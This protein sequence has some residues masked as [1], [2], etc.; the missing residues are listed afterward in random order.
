MPPLQ[1]APPLRL[2]LLSLSLLLLLFLGP[3]LAGAQDPPVANTTFGKVV[4]FTRE[5][6]DIW[7]NVPYAA[8]PV[9]DLRFRPPRDPQPWTEALD[10]LAT[11]RMCPQNRNNKTRRFDGSEDCLILNVYAPANRSS[12][13]NGQQPLLPV[14][15]FIHGGGF[16]SGSGY[17]YGVNLPGL[18]DLY[19]GAQFA[20]QT[21]SVV[22]GV[23]YRLGL[24]G[25]LAHDAL[26]GEQADGTTGNYGLQDQRLALRWVQANARHF[27]GDSDRVMLF[28]ESAGAISVCYH[29][30]SLASAGLFAT[31]LA[32]SPICT[33]RLAFLDRKVATNFGSLWAAHFGCNSSGGGTAECLRGLDVASV[34]DGDEDWRD[35]LPPNPPTSPPL[36][37]YLPGHAWWPVVDGAPSGLEQDPLQLIR[38]G[39]FN[40]VPTIIGTNHDEGTLFMTFV[41]KVLP[42]VTLPL[43]EAEFKR[44]VGYF[45]ANNATIVDAVAAAYGQDG[46]SYTRRM[47]DVL[48]DY[49]FV[50][51][52]RLTLRELNR[53][54][55]LMNDTATGTWMYNFNRT[56]PGFPLWDL[57]RDFHGIELFYVFDRP[58]PLLWRW[59]PED[60][61]LSDQMQAYWSTFAA[62]KD[63]N[64]TGGQG[65]GNCTGC[66]EWPRYTAQANGDGDVNLVFQHTLKVETG[67]FQTNCDFWD[68]VGY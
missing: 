51:P 57:I 32:E 66:V 14:L 56:I 54:R 19:D 4:G 24:L 27:G 12:N 68:T 15:V 21:N 48:R 62:G 58:Q 1:P 28:G 46:D 5:G 39:K 37:L 42:N 40:N 31:A 20:R 60:Q 7:W 53:R 22:V 35:L 49:L 25:F 2:S 59:R 44:V 9:G 63:P 47:E 8:P 10:C 34:L 65:R 52:T 67:L 16:T 55:A 11:P 41:P 3:H 29:L 64:P 33:G 17:S 23:N 61:Q 50:C 26:A 36:P 45:F 6:V 38:E 30:V 43:N 13:T 18:A